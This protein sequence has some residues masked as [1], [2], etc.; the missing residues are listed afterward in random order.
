MDSKN[1]T[2]TLEQLEIKKRLVNEETDLT[3]EC[4]SIEELNRRIGILLNEITNLKN[5]IDEQNDFISQ[6]CDNLLPD[7]KILNKASEISNLTTQLT[8]LDRLCRRIDSSR[9]LGCK[10]DESKS[11]GGRASSTNVDGNENVEL[12][13]QEIEMLKTFETTYKPLENLLSRRKD[14]PY[15]SYAN[16][17]RKFQ[18]VLEQ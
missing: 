17:V 4:Q 12:S 14:L 9:A 6:T 1:L 8:R 3:K 13:D 11:L 16:N 5:T 15:E 10:H 18:F 7:Y 2:K